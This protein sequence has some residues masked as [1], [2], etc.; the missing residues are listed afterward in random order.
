M[1]GW[2]SRGS[3]RERESERERALSTGGSLSLFQYVLHAVA[4]ETTLRSHFIFLGLSARS[5]KVDKTA[6]CSQTL[7]YLTEIES[8]SAH[9]CPKLWLP[10]DLNYFTELAESN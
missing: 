7:T 3:P 1:D 10:D 2:R 9:L 5:V 4:I 8:R 6:Q